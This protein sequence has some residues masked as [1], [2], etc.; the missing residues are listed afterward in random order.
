[1]KQPPSQLPPKKDVVLAL[2]EQS[3]AF[4]HL[5]PRHEGVRVPPWFKKQAQLVLQVGLNMAVPIPDLNVD[6]EGVTCTLSFSRSPFFCVLP[7][8]AVYALV[9]EDGRGMVWPADVP[10]EVVL[11]TQQRQVEPEAAPKPQPKGKGKARA[12][13]RAVASEGAAEATPAEPPAGK[14]TPVAAV[15]AE[16]AP[17]GDADPAQG[18]LF[19]EGEGAPA[20]RLVPTPARGGTPSRKSK[21]ELPPY[22]RVVK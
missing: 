20:P 5:D 17:T 7:W 13:L 14:P 19:P 1:M 3:S 16:P 9:G 22:L 21:K 11:P 8:A 15:A 4:I 12:R 6:D 10:P 18:E 2:L